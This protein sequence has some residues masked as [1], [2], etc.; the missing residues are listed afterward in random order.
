MNG[1][2]Y[3]KAQKIAGETS[4]D[5]I[6]ELKNNAATVPNEVQAEVIPFLYGMSKAIAYNKVLD[7][8]FSDTYAKYVD[9]YNELGSDGLVRYYLAK[10]VAAD[11]SASGNIKE[12]GLED[13]L[14]MFGFAGNE[15][16]YL[17]KVYNK[18][19]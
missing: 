18:K 10:K 17:K 4:Y 19:W 1:E 5:L 12:K 15:I 16:P 6:M 3:S 14:E 8:P 13:S 11:H 2:E 7:K 9:V